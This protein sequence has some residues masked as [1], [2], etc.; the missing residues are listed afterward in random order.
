MF[1]RD[2]PVISRNDT[3][4][5]EICG[6][7]WSNLTADDMIAVAWA[8]YYF[9]IQFRENLL[10]ACASLPDDLA[11]KRL[12]AEE[13]DTS[14]L[15]PYPGIAEAGEKMNHD[16]FMRRALKFHPLKVEIRSRFIRA[17]ANYLKA[18]HRVP[19]QIRSQSM[20]SYEDGGLERVFRAMLTAPHY[21]DPLLNA[22]RFFLTEHIRF[23]SDPVAG[24]GNLSRHLGD[25]DSVAEL[26]RLFYQ[27]LIENTPGLI[28]HLRGGRLHAAS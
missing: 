7:N 26:W 27:L 25:D 18:V 4:I 14:N 28:H 2:A 23:D 3:V 5:D 16:E 6:L 22:F 15:S 20:A 24:H 8:Y 21:D 10:I 13:C 9:S 12:L 11:M 1:V 17:G 19:P